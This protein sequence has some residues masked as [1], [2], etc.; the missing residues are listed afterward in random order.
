MRLCLFGPPGSGKGTQGEKLS[1]EYGIPEVSTG[2]L[3]RAAV[4]AGSELGQK[5][6]EAMSQGNLVADDVVV[7]MIRERLHEA[8]AEPGFILD[9]FPRSFGQA[10]ALQEMLAAEGKPLHRVIHLDVDR[11]EIIT[12]LMARKRADDN[13]A[14]IRN[15]LEVYSSQTRPVLEYFKER[16]LLTTIQGVGEVDEIYANI[17]AAIA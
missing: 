7:G 11:E 9:G 14:T 16:D 3:L 5:A 10:E 2:D 1:E 4:A 6:Q 12:R 17:K 13:E 15:R 8:D